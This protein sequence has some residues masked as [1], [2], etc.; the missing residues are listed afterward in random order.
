VWFDCYFARIITCGVCITHYHI[1]QFTLH[2]CG[3]W[4]IL[5][6]FRRFTHLCFSVWLTLHALHLIL[7][8]KRWCISKMTIS[9]L[10]HVSKA[11]KLCSMK[12]MYLRIKHPLI[13]SNSTACT[14]TIHTDGQ[15]TCKWVPPNIARNG[16]TMTQWPIDVKLQ[17]AE[18]LS[19][20]GGGVGYPRLWL[21]RQRFLRQGGDWCCIYGLSPWRM[22]SVGLMHNLSKMMVI[23]GSAGD[24]RFSWRC[25][26]SA[27]ACVQDM[28]RIPYI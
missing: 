7:S 4:L 3:I 18:V 8:I 24:A 13:P 6:P 23:P 9:Q 2:L 15:S 10:H 20:A 14:C 28:L 12:L 21:S 17:V 1:V 27:H 22:A 25:Q 5:H 19:R 16:D 26:L 11:S